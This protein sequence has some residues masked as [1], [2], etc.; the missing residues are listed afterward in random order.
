MGKKAALCMGALVLAAPFLWAGDTASFVDLGFSADGRTYIFAQYGVQS[1]GLKPWAD[2]FVVDVPANNFVP[3]GKASYVHDSPVSAGQ[4]GT[5][6]LY[7]V[8]ARNAA[9]ADQYGVSF[10]LQ[11]QPLY[12]A[13]EN[14]GP[15][16]GESIEFRDFQKGYTYKASL[17]P[18]V[19]GSGAGLK[20]SFYI[21]LERTSR[22]G[23]KKTYTVGNP[24]V[25]R[26]LIGSY[27]IAKVVVAPGDGSMIFVIETRKTAGGDTEIR[28]MVEALRL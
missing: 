4:D 18:Y 16:A 13:L 19:E 3:R 25:K 28:Y 21:N 23:S 7:R 6:A 5:G 17:V 11:G 10:L 12:I 20:S 22:D 8:I 15:A 2:M 27:R 9:L 1:S 14:G 26:S 24:Q